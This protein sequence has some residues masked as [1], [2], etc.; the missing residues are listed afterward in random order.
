MHCLRLVE[1]CLEKVFLSLLRPLYTSRKIVDIRAYATF[2]THQRLIFHSL[3][4]Q[5][6]RMKSA[7]NTIRTGFL[8]EPNN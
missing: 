7:L 4:R 8:H 3:V 6:V 1:L 5:D 2:L